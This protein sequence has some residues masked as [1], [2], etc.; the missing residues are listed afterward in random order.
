MKP[1]QPGHAAG[2]KWR[3]DSAGRVE[4]PWAWSE[5]NGGEDL[6]PH[7]NGICELGWHTDC[8][9]APLTSPAGAG[10]CSC[11][12]HQRED[13]IMTAPTP[14]AF[15]AEPSTDEDDYEETPTIDGNDVLAGPL[16]LSGGFTVGLDSMHVLPPDPLESMA[17]SLRQIV[18]VMTGGGGPA[19]LIS[20]LEKEVSEIEALHDAKQQLIEDV[21][22]ICKPSTS[23]L[24][25]SIRAVLEPVV[26][27]PGVEGVGSEPDTSRADATAEDYARATAEATG[28][29]RWPAHDADVEEWRSY[30]R[31]LLPDHD[32]STMNRSQIRTALNIPQPT[33]D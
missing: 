4:R 30:A 17:A 29:P 28:I 21:L 32:V 6:P 11:P 23:K 33:E 18:D 10:Q 12:C 25:N 16:T 20:D 3:Q 1:Q 26:A 19:Q 14:E 13:R 31:D 5:I 7:V 8:P 27:P 2:W 24:A 15:L 22:T 9:Q